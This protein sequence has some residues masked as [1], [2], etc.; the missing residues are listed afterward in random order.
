MEQRFGDIVNEYYIKRFRQIFRKRKKIL[1]S[2]TTREQA[3]QYI[4]EVRKK[5]R[6]CFALDLEPRTPLNPVITA[7]HKLDSATLECIILESRPGFFI[8][9]NLYLPENRKNKV[10]GVL[11]LCG[12]D[13]DGKACKKYSIF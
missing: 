10:P 7:V 12:H 4:S 3:L 2:I 9:T 8:T 6:K 11:L 13:P 1:D 5:I